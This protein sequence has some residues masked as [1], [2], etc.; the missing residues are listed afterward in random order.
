M[1]KPRRNKLIYAFFAWYIN[2]IIKTDFKEFKFNP[3]EFD[4]ERAVLLLAN[5][6]SWWDGF[7][8][9]HL[10]RIC[11]HKKFHV[12]ITE[13][14]YRQVWFLKYLGGFSVK[15]NS[16]SSIETLAYAGQLLNDPQNLVLIFPQGKLHSHHVDRVDFQKGL[17]NL[18]NSSNKDFEY[19]FAAFFTDY[20]QYRNPSV[21]CYL[22]KH[23]GA[24]FDSLE[25]IANAYNEH[26]QISKQK[27][28]SI[29]V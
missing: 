14:N 23:N 26:Y 27:Q 22:Q 2:R 20:F 7:L 18:V 17:S 15:K 13:E 3:I 4:Q 29:T 6:F 12:M 10:N 1:L 5:H 9:F 19:I 25:L 21:R 11:F 24:E 8:L 16:R 28:S